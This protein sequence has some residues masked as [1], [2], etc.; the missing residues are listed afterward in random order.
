MRAA[1]HFQKTAQR[2]EDEDGFSSSTF[3]N[4]EN[5]IIS[6]E[7]T[8]AR[9]TLIRNARAIA[10]VSD[11]MEISTTEAKARE[12]EDIIVLDTVIE[13]QHLLQE[14]VCDCHFLK[15]YIY[16]SNRYL[17]LFMQVLM[18]FGTKAEETL[19]FDKL[20][21]RMAQIEERKAAKQGNESKS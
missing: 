10:T 9:M 8:S 1:K 12:S 13:T 21:N 16:R 2:F 14:T 11:L 18:H 17:F 5:D 4:L 6:H 20:E 7:R 15:P 3:F 19:T